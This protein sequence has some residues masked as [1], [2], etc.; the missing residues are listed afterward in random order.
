MLLMIVYNL[1]NQNEKALAEGE[2]A[3]AILPNSSDLNLA[4]ARVLA[5]VGRYEEAITRVKRAMRLN[6]YHQPFYF[7]ILGSCYRIAG[8]FEE[9]IDAY[10]RE[11]MLAPDTLLPWLA[12]AG[13][14]AALGREKEAKKATE[15][16]H[17]MAPDY[18]WE[19]YGK[20]YHQFHDK[21]IERRF[22]DGLHKC[23]L[24]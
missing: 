6:P 5:C 14:Y 10:E 23:G 19:K 24:K 4:F 16:V 3:F 11:V 1:Q 22:F 2:K 8:R 12:L 20:I 18:S 15:Q 13:L 7:T 21:E 9:A 17:R